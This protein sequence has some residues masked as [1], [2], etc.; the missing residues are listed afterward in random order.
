MGGDPAA[1]L[2]AMHHP[3]PH[4][5]MMQ[6]MHPHFAMAQANLQAQQHRLVVEQQHAEALD[7]AGQRRRHEMRHAH[8]VRLHRSRLV[9][10]CCV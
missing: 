7:P 8:D 10:Q 1:L 9:V 5:A 2:R 4:F 3:H 6:H